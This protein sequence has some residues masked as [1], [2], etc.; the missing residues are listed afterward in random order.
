MSE[1]EFLELS[2]V[3]TGIKVSSFVRGKAAPRPGDLAPVNTPIPLTRIYLEAADQGAVY[4]GQLDDLW[5]GFKARN[6]PREAAVA[7]LQ[8]PK[9]GKLCRSIM[10]LWY[11]GV[12]YDPVK[13]SPVRVVSSQ[14]YKEG[15]VWKVMQA[16]P[17]GYSMR[18]FGYWAA[19]PP[20][21]DRF[22]TVNS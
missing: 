5:N 16:H 14:A 11:L 20:E 1:S 13:N 7:L 4:R 21:L 15:L 6:S 18:E 17:Q 9:H 22:I 12:W 2:S 10:K 3:L 8:D 19:E